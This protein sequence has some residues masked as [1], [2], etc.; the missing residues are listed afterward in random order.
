MAIFKSVRSAEYV[1]DKESPENKNRYKR[2]REESKELI[3]PSLKV[4]A[5]LIA[6]SGIFAMIFEARYFSGFSVQVYLTRLSATVI[7]FGVLVL[8]FSRH[9]YNY[10]TQLVHVLMFTIIVSSGYMIYLLPQTLVINSH[11]LG[12]I[13]FTSALFLSWD[14][15][16]QVIT[17]IYYNLVFGAS[18]MLNNDGGSYHPNLLESIFFVVFLSVISVIGSAM[19]FRLRVQLADKTHRIQLS[20]KKFKAIFDNSLEGIFQ[21]TADGH[22]ITVNDSL[23]KILGYSSKEELMKTNISDQI[24]INPE[25]RLRLLARLKSDGEVRNYILKLKKKD[26]SPVIVRLNDRVVHDND[27]SKVFYEGNMQDISEQ[28]IADEKR[29]QMEELL[30]IEKEK[31]DK[32]A[33]EAQESN[34]IKSQ[35]LANMSHEIRTPMN[36]IIGYLTLIEKGAYEDSEEMKEFAASAKDSA[37]AL[38]DIINNILDLSKIESGKMVISET[39]FNLIEI[40]D[41]A[42]SIVSSKAAEKKLNIFRNITGNTPLYLTG[43]G[44]RLRQV[45]INLLSNSIKFTDK[46]EI[47]ITA[48][49]QGIK[50]GNVNILFSVKD[51][52]VGIAKDKI[53]TLFQPFSQVD[54]SPTR[55]YGG[56]GLGLAICR[57]FVTMMG[58]DISVES[59]EGEGSDFSF[60][61]LFKLSEKEEKGENQEK[62]RVYNFES[63]SS[64]LKENNVKKLKEIRILLAEDNIINQRIA[65][66][67]LREAGFFVDTAESGMEA[68]NRL[69]SSSYNLVLMDIQMPDMDGFMV[70]E[71][72]RNSGA[73][74]KDIPIIAITAHAMSGYK[75]KCLRAGMN[76][77]ITKPVVAEDLIVKINNLL[78]LNIPVV[79][80]EK[81]VPAN[82]QDLLFDFDQLNR[83]S[84]GEKSFQSELLSTFI[85]DADQRIRVL[86]DHLQNRD[87]DAILKEAHT[88]KG[89]GNSIGAVMIA[90]HALAVEISAKSNDID[91]ATRHFIKLFSS[92]KETKELL[93]TSGMI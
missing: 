45:F 90:A 1:I 59:R 70:T 9:S 46:G 77:Y 80:I 58:G 31:S 87:Y 64:G 53:A 30:R 17:V 12:L 40:I 91:N 57:E 8:L 23:V 44:A 88:I 16:Q 43:D 33:S 3:I 69:G 21:S 81:T 84:L 14:V 15:K 24:Y 18:I 60:S 52:G 39:P 89:A 61:L 4:L 73:E 56:T 10:A 11:I 74:Y 29:K 35:F 38:M 85:E 66:L 67:I 68:L 5:L 93:K 20:E 28:V 6:V 72:I 36:G 79:K 37:D 50:N 75:E 63:K 55:R 51:T 62:T 49:E 26:G 86:E 54:S 13:I 71:R 65:V 32:L 82:S 27:R 83:M 42:V 92:M 78:K 41:D 34:V 47:R 22:Y 76:D 19:S 25:D 2:V 7:S 48:S